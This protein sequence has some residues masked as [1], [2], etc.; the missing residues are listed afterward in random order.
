[1][2]LCASARWD[3]AK[4]MGSIPWNADGHHPREGQPVGGGSMIILENN[5]SDTYRRIL[6]ILE[7]MVEKYVFMVG[8]LNHSSKI[9]A[10][11]TKCLL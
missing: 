4:T 5:S 3:E 1:M 6:H 2:S 10:S 8:P 11:Y 7:S 9:L